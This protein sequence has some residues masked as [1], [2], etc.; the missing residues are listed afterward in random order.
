MLTFNKTNAVRTTDNDGCIKNSNNNTTQGR[1]K[2]TNLKRGMM[3]LVGATR[4][5]SDRN[6][7]RPVCA[8]MEK[9]RRHKHR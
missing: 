4:F 5:R 1:Y 7:V 3:I 6:C 2:M 9:K 8:G